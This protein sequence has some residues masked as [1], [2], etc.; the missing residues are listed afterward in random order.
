MSTEETIWSGSPSQLKNLGTYVLCILTFFLIVP[1]FVMTWVWLKTK[2]TKYQLTNERLIF[3]RGV[4][5]KS[6]DQ[7]ELYRVRDYRFEQPFVLR[8]FGL[9]NIYLIGTDVTDEVIVVEAVR[10]GSDIVNTIRACVENLRR[11]KRRVF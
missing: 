11:V 1:I 7:F 3:T 4:L 2:F 5:S 8:V 9:G 6:T 10:N